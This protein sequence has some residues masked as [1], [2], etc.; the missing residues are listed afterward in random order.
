MLTEKRLQV[1]T[2]MKREMTG[3]REVK[4]IALCD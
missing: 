1:D 3:K 4:Q 2:G